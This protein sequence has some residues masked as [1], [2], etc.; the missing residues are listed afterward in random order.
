LDVSI[1]L[2][3]L[4]LLD[5]LRTERNLAMLYVTHD[6]ATARHFASEILVM[7]RGRIVERGPSDQVILTPRH[8][9][10]QLLAQSAPRRSRSRVAPVAKAAPTP[11]VPAGGDACVFIA[12]CPHA[13]PA[14]ARRPPDVPVADGVVVSCWLADLDAPAPVVG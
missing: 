8:P 2:E 7:Y 4:G 3:I 9:Y 10:T 14:C 11:R 5:R 12:R 1:R 6:L 13:M